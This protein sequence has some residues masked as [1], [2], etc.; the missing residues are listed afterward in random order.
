MNKI[1]KANLLFEKMVNITDL[2]NKAYPNDD[3]EYHPQDGEGCYERIY[4]WYLIT[5][6][7][8][9]EDVYDHLKHLG[10]NTIAFHEYKDDYYIGFTWY[11]THWTNV[12]D[13]TSLAEAVIPDGWVKALDNKK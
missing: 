3:I 4:F 8:L 12:D 11:G 2:F 6:P 7:V 9:G 13:F 5:D 1:V 10:G